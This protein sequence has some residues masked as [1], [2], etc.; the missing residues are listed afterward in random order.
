M[1]EGLLVN[2]PGQSGDGG[3]SHRVVQRILLL[4]LLGLLLCQT[5]FYF[6]FTSTSLSQT[7]KHIDNHK[8]RSWTSINPTILYIYPFSLSRLEANVSQLFSTAQLFILPQKFPVLS[9]LYLCGGDVE[10]S[11]LAWCCL[12]LKSVSLSNFIFWSHYMKV[13]GRCSLVTVRPRARW[14]DNWCDVGGG[15]IAL[16]S[17]VLLPHQP[18]PLMGVGSG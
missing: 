8:Q 18:P 17:R 7:I 12:A 14:A 2:G 9:E 16:V 11:D 15:A 6:H 10:A 1:G 3:D 5:A 4:P 13:E